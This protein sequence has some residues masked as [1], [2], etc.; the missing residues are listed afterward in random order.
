MELL[1]SIAVSS[2]YSMCGTNVWSRVAQSMK[3]LTT[4]IWLQPQTLHTHTHT[5]ALGRVKASVPC[6]PDLVSRDTEVERIVSCR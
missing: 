5:P 3:W 1:N 4:G 2:L 6:R